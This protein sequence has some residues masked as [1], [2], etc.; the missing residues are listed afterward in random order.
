MIGGFFPRFFTRLLVVILL[1]WIRL[2]TLILLAIR[3]ILIIWLAL[4]RHV[5]E[6]KN[7]TTDE[8]GVWIKEM[9]TE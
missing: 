7:D 5:S 3:L 6:S 9:M 4:V 8:E 2:V 1:L